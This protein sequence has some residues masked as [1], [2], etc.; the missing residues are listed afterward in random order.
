LDTI[1]SPMSGKIRAGGESRTPREANFQSPGAHLTKGVGK[2]VSRELRIV[3]SAACLAGLLLTLGV[4]ASHI[5]LSDSHHLVTKA[6]AATINAYN[7]SDAP[8]AIMLA[9]GNTLAAPAALTRLSILPE[10]P[11][12]ARLQESFQHNRA[13]PVI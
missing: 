6:S 5:R 10:A 13:P 11:Y 4:R 3:V 8:D 2:S 12:Q 1:L 9:A 7:L